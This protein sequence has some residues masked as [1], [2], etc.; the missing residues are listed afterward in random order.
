[1][2][3]SVY[4]SISHLFSPLLW[5][6]LLLPRSR[7]CCAQS[8]TGTMFGY[9]CA[10]GDA[11]INPLS[12]RWGLT[13]VT[14]S[15]VERS[16]LSMFEPFVSSELWRV[17]TLTDRN[18]VTSR[19]K[20]SQQILNI[21]EYYCYFLP[22]LTLI[23][24]C[25]SKVSAWRESAYVSGTQP[26]CLCVRVCLCLCVCFICLKGLLTGVYVCVCVCVCVCAY[27][28]CVCFCRWTA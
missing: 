17:T 5:V 9:Y 15:C 14:S 16:V 19:C 10:H 25:N 13:F 20:W 1:M 6:F 8:S 11:L 12:S 18:T 26:L 21:I 2:S 22:S 23:L 28:V 27:F 3:T 24:Y 4:I 7:Y